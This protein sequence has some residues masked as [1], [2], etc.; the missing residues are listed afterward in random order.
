MKILDAATQACRLGALALALNYAFPVCAAGSYPDHPIR[1]IVPAAP[2]GLLDVTTRLVARK[3]SEAL[4]VSIIVDNRPG[5][6]TLVGTQVVKTAQPDG[7][8]LLSQANNMTAR[9]AFYK[10]SGYDLMKD[11]VP[12]GP[13]IRAPLVMLVPPAGPGTFG[14]WIDAARAQ[15]DKVA[16]ASGGV[17]TPQ[18]VAAALLQ[19]DAR[20]TLLHVPYSGNGAAMPDVMSG[21]VNMIFDGYGSSIGY[22][23]SQKLHP[24][25]V[26]SGKRLDALPDV[27]AI[28]EQGYP[29]YSYYLWLGLFAPTGTPN[30]AIQRLSDALH[31]ALT[32]KDLAE[33]F[34]AEGSEPMMM[35]PAQFGEFLHRDLSRM[36][37]LVKEAGIQ[38]R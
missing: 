14:E 19:H 26:T 15:P 29:N 13:M 30:E 18:Y 38:K 34:R 6:E 2:G 10:D 9:P 25:G 21:R 4:G 12:V 24:I 17:G 1:M 20:L 3:M 36:S 27:P 31:K 35:T 11:F 5:G 32:S 8:T 33:R 7:Y 22:I 23:K 16:F 37:E 28:A